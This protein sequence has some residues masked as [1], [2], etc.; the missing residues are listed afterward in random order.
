MNLINEYDKTKKTGFPFVESGLSY[1][2][3][4]KLYLVRTAFSPR[5]EAS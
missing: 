2:F 3:I 5:K 1:S 4:G